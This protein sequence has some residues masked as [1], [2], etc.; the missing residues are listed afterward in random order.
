MKIR[1]ALLCLIT[2]V[3]LATPAVQV[4]DAATYSGYVDGSC[5]INED[6]L[7]SQSPK[8]K[9]GTHTLKLG[10][11]SST[12]NANYFKICPSKN[13]TVKIDAWGFS[14]DFTKISNKSFRY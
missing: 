3:A 4:V 12:E 1:K 6:S 14:N 5:F 9:T 7:T 2:G 13:C 11:K 10:F 8:L